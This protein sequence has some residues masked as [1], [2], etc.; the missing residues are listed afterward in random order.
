MNKLYNE[1]CRIEMFKYLRG[2][3]PCGET[4]FPIWNR[5]FFFLNIKHFFMETCFLLEIDFLV[6]SQKQICLWKLA[7]LRGYGNGLSYGSTFLYSHRN[8]FSYGNSFLDEY[9]NGL[10]YQ[11]KI[12]THENGLSYGNGYS[13]IHGNGLF[14]VVMGTSFLIERGLH[15]WSW[16][17]AFLYSHGNRLSYVVRE[18]GFHMKTCFLMKNK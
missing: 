3:G 4:G 10:S 12:Y 2:L 1:D 16:K 6:Q 9:G 15:I 17:R 7:F 11:N 18:I 5:A 14:Y 8:G 13:Y